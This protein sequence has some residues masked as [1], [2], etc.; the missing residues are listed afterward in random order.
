M[1]PPSTPLHPAACGVGRAAALC[2]AMLR[3]FLLGAL[4]ALAGATHGAGDL[5][6]EVVPQLRS[7][8]S[9]VS[10]LHRF[11][12]YLYVPT[13]AEAKAAS[14][15]I[16]SKGLSVEVRRA[17]TGSTWLCLVKSNVVPDSH[18]LTEIGRLLTALAI[19][20]QGEFDGWEAEVVKLGE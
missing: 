9:D 19:E 6:I 16:R 5:R 20:Y 17:A 4:T 3:T 15:K 13:D 11:D 14:L 7:V 2:F 18:Q 1:F 8:G 12:F 10:R